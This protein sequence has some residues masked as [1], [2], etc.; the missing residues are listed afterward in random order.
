[1]ARGDRKKINHAGKKA[2]RNISSSCLLGD[3]VVSWLIFHGVRH[4]MTLHAIT[5]ARSAWRTA[6]PGGYKKEA[7]VHFTLP[8]RQRGGFGA[9]RNRQKFFA[10][11]FQK[12]RFFLGLFS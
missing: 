11:F 4:A 8:R 10:S 1:V 2:R 12:R 3:F 5:G 6:C 9:T 7:F